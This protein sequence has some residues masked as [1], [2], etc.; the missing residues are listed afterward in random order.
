M[1]GIGIGELSSIALAFVV[2]AVTI[3]IGATILSST[4]TGQ[5]TNSYAYNATGYGLTGTNTLATWLQ[6][7]AVIIAAAVV[8]GIIVNAFRTG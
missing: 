1:K 2:V 8:I 6:T 7:I 4:Q 3:S 5:T